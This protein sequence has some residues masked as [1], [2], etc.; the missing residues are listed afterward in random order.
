MATDVAHIIQFPLQNVIATVTRVEL[1]QRTYTTHV[2][3]SVNTF[4]PTV[5]SRPSALVH[6]KTADIFTLHDSPTNSFTLYA[7]I[8]FSAIN[9]AV[10]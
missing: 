6:I 8:L 4:G 10:S 2:M 7:N 5:G 1:A 9:L 3:F